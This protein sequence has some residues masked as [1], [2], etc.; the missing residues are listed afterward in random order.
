MGGKTHI[1]SLPWKV[2]WVRLLLAWYQVNSSSPSV[3]VCIPAHARCFYRLVL[4]SYIAILQSH[5]LWF[6]YNI[7]LA[8]KSCLI[9]FYCSWLNQ[10]HTE[11]FLVVLKKSTLK[12]KYAPH[13][14]AYGVMNTQREKGLDSRADCCRCLFHLHRRQESWSQE[15]N[16]HTHL[17]KQA[18]ESKLGLKAITGSHKWA[19]KRLSRV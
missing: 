8:L 13:T 1:Q 3:S 4:P 12:Q 10:G 6:Y 14:H 16:G 15:R 19:R 11:W 18:G 5:I 9:T 7:Q 2:P 17:G